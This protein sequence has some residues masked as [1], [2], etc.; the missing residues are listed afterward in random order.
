MPD[1]DV[2]VA[3]NGVSP[4]GIRLATTALFVLPA[5]V[6]VLPVNLLPFGILLLASTVLALPGLLSMWAALG[7][8][9]WLLLAGSVGVVAL[10]VLSVWW[11][12]HALHA[13]D[14]L[15]RLM[16]VPWLV[17][18][19]VYW[20]PSLSHL[21]RGAVLGLVAMA[22]LVGWQFAQGGLRP[23]GWVNPIVLADGAVALLA[24][25]VFC[26]PH[27]RQ[28]TGMWLA[29]FSSLV[30][31][32]L[33]GSRGAWPAWLLVVVA[34]FLGTGMFSKATRWRTV[35]TVTLVTLFLLA[36][37][38]ALREQMRLQEFG[39]D[40]I[41][42]ENGD[43]DSS[44]GARLRLWQLAG[45]TFNDRPLTG[46]GVGRFDQ[47]VQTLPE[48]RQGAEHHHVCGLSHAHND[49]AEWLATG[50]VLGLLG[51]LLVYGAPVVLYWRRWRLTDWSSRGSAPAGLML[52]AVYVLCG[53]TQSMFSHQLTAGLYAVL[54]GILLGAD[55][56]PAGRPIPGGPVPTAR[57]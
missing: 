40:V 5:T 53:L 20:R 17:C 3:V 44:L 9:R 32:I 35:A 49:A 12:D 8:G 13:L 30:V 46:T 42:L 4:A 15:S 7:R 1:R 2:A 25:A 16:V 45:D 27:G 50:G 24:L 11:H 37:N 6:F 57:A 52:V 34:A 56:R 23:S 38:P 18:W 22:M 29:L 31:L 14:N 39:E 19:M 43:G 48:C 36:I 51:L 26:R 41:R 28:R 10:A 33:T 47:A 54:V 21:Q 55:W